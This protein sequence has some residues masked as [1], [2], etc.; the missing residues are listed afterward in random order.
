[1]PAVGLEPT[2]PLACEASALPTELSGLP[3]LEGWRM[4]TKHLLKR[5]AG[6]ISAMLIDK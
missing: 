3:L 1:V 2:K 4:L 6:R 5:Q